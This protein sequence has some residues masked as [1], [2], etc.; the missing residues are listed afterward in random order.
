MEVVEWMDEPEVFDPELPLVTR[1]IAA[2][3]ILPPP[4]TELVSGLESVTYPPGSAIH[5]MLLTG[6]PVSV[7]VNDEF[8]TRTVIHQARAQLLQRQR[9]GLHPHR[10]AH[11]PGHGPG[12]HHVRTLR[13]QA[14]LHRRGP[15]PGR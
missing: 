14:G 6:R 15:Q 13:R 5:R 10:P 2:G 3:T 8:M 4:A 1:R 12:H 7:L 11:R 9:P